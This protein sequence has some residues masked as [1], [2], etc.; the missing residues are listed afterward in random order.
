MCTK[1]IY[2]QSIAFIELDHLLKDIFVGWLRE[3]LSSPLP[4]KPFGLKINEMR[5]LFFKVKHQHNAFKC[6]M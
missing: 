2:K 1:S 6:S 4:I 3:L 5:V